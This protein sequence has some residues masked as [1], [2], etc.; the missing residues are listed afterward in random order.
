M[1]VIL[2]WDD[3][4]LLDGSGEVFK[5]NGVVG[6]S[7][8]GNTNF[9]PHRPL[10][11]LFTPRTS[12]KVTEIIGAQQFYQNELLELKSKVL[13]IIRL[14]TFEKFHMDIIRSKAT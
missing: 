6:A 14:T 1:N 5:P 3:P 9:K 2:V 12:Y 8:F 11:P 10:C 13:E 7:T 4:K